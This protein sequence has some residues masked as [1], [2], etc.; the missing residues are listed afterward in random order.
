M[1]AFWPSC[2]CMQQLLS[3]GFCQISNCSLCNSILEMGV[4]AAKEDWSV[5]K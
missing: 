1:Y 2:S 5:M 3:C 4:D